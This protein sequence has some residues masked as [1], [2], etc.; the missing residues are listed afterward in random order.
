MVR[1][2]G[3]RA[4]V[5]ARE[6]RCWRVDTPAARG[7]QP[8]IRGRT[9]PFAPGLSSI[10]RAGTCSIGTPKRPAS[11]ASLSSATARNSS[12]RHQQRAGEALRPPLVERPLLE[13]G[14]HLEGVQRE[15]AGEAHQR[16][17]LL[18]LGQLH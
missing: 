11:S 17:I 3:T 1:C 13:P 6:R 9:H 12:G 7:P 14:R 2:F 10:R 8:S 5:R 15:R 18:Q 16:M 4:R